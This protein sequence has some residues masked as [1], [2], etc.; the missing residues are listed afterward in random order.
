MGSAGPAPKAPRGARRVLYWSLAAIFFALAVL[1]VALPG[2]PTTPFLLLTSWCLLRCS[3]RL[4]AKLRASR[5]FGPLLHDWEEHR[6]VRLAVKV[7]AF[8][9]ML[10]IGGVSLL[11]LDMPTLW[12]VLVGLLLLSGMVVVLRLRTVRD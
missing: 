11:L 3:P 12:C 4:H 5:L 10:C 8:T 6:G 9:L 1:G 7:A 2:L